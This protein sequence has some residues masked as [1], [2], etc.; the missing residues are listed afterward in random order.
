M[1]EHLAAVLEGLRTLTALLA[2]REKVI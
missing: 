2:L 1:S